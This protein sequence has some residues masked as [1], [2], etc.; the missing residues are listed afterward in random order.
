MNEASA[1]MAKPQAGMVALF[2]TLVTIQF[3]ENVPTAAKM[4]VM[5][6]TLAK[7]I[8]SPTK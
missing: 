7:R 3:S 1:Q 5:V 6:F 4:G 8:W 2:L